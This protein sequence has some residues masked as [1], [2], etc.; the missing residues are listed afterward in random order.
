MPQVQAEAVF[1][2]VSQRPGPAHLLTRRGLAKAVGIRSALDLD[3]LRTEVGEQ[4]A[5]LPACDDNAEV[6]DP[7]AVKRPPGR[8]WDRRCVGTFCRPYCFVFA[9]R[10]RGLRV[11]GVRTID[12][13]RPDRNGHGRVRAECDVG[14]CADSPEVFRRQC[15]RGREHCGDRDPA[16]LTL[17]HQV[18][19]RLCGEHLR[20]GL[21][22]FA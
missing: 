12:D 11:T 17:G 9:E 3:D 7:E 4:P 14:E 15:P 1:V 21:V 22:E 5:Q 18:A 13:E 20:D 16:A 10:R 19:H 6:E 8:T 2:A